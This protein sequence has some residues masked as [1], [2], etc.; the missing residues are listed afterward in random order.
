M[1]VIVLIKTKKAGG[2]AIWFS[3]NFMVVVRI[4][5]W[6]T[7]NPFTQGGSRNEPL[8]DLLIKYLFQLQY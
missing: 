1:T 3:F 2:R 8:F 5:K 6:R 4:G 7:I